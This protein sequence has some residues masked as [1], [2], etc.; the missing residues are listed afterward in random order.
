MYIE[1]IYLNNYKNYNEVNFEFTNDINVIYGNNAQGKTNL[2]ESIYLLSYGK[3]FRGNINENIVN[4]KE[5][6]VF[7]KANFLKSNRKQNISFFY[8]KKTNKKY[9]KV[10]EVA[11]N[12]ISNIYGKLHIVTY[13]PEDIEIIKKGPAIR[14]KYID[15]LISSIKPMY[16][17]L[18]SNYNLIVK[19]R[20]SFLKNNKENYFKD[21]NLVDFNYLEVLNIK[22]AEYANSI[23]LYRKKYIE[24]INDIAN[25]FHFSLL[26]QKNEN[27]TF[28]YKSDSEDIKSFNYKLKKSE[29]QDFLRGYTNRGIHRDDIIIK[30]NDRDVSLFGSQ[31]QQKSSILSL[32]LAEIKIIEKESGE[33]PILLLD[34]FM[35]ELDEMRQKL[36]IENIKNYQIIITSTSKIIIKN[37]K[38]RLYNI[39]N[40]KII[41][42][43][44]INPQ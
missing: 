8:D 33:R 12:K 35:S 29:Y 27:L 21:K 6:N 5:D 9:F 11:Q 4:F 34:D 20:N 7:I 3:T 30:I 10:N 40:G 42:K 23:Y 26:K 28:E 19:Q 37:R 13:Q 43:E 14:R 22:L 31:G 25:T 24:L 15:T 1:D 41:S 18:L 17:S 16:I 32:K 36:F 39:N 38:N 44:D 2:L